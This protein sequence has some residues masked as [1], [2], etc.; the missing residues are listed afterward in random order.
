MSKLHIN[1]EHLSMIA[2]RIYKGSATLTVSEATFLIL[3]SHNFANTH[4]GCED[5][6]KEQHDG[7]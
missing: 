5:S 3:E 6:L 4:N 2:A 7:I 1:P